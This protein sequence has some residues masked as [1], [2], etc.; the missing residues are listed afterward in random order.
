VTQTNF[1][2]LYRGRTVA[3]SRL[4][5]MTAEPEIVALFVREITGAPENTDKSEE[6]SVS[7]AKPFEVVRGGQD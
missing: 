1:I 3:E 7:T 4:I 2:A 5:A 6:Q